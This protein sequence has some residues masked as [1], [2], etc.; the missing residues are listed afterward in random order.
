MYDKPLTK[1]ATA[2]EQ[3]GE[4]GQD[5]MG[6]VIESVRGEGMCWE[7]ERASRVLDVRLEAP[8]VVLR[9]VVACLLTNRWKANR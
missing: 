8:G 6:D 7:I 2:T 9:K 3:L 4:H 1:V 5:E